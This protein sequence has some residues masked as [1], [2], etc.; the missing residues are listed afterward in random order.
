MNFNQIKIISL[1]VKDQQAAKNLDQ[2]RLGF[3]PIREH[4]MSENAQWIQLASSKASSC[5]LFQSLGLINDVSA[6]LKQLREQATRLLLMCSYP[7][8]FHYLT[9]GVYTVDKLVSIECLV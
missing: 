4:P 7:S 2:N 3:E 5:S 8:L 9:I 6:Q 1:P